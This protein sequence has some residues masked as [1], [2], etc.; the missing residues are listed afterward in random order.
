MH[1]TNKMSVPVKI[2]VFS[3]PANPVIAD[4]TVVYVIAK[5][6]AVPLPPNK[7]NLHFFLEAMVLSPHPGNPN[8]PNYD[9]ITPDNIVPWC[10]AIGSVTT[11]TLPLADNKSHSLDLSVSDYVH[12]AVASSAIWCRFEGSN[13]RW[14]RGP[15][16]PNVSSIIQVAGPL[17]RTFS[18]GHVEL[19]I[20]HIVLS[21]GVNT[22]ASAAAA[23]PTKKRKYAA[24][25][26][27]NATPSTLTVVDVT[28]SGLSAPTSTSASAPMAVIEAAAASSEANLAPPLDDST[29]SVVPAATLP[30]MSKYKGKGKASKAS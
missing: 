16:K 10:W 13:A 3:S 2:R 24:A 15:L 5:V 12:D 14:A 22:D 11:E 1:F 17:A 23:S 19:T 7:D 26:P 18:P 25:A 21:L 29:P 27:L 30:R 20:E 28:A 8:D 4:G 9:D 6:T